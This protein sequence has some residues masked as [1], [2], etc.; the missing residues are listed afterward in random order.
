M[1]LFLLFSLICAFE[2]YLSS[3]VV[4]TA[5]KNLLAKSAV[6]RA[7]RIINELHLRTDIFKGSL[8]DFNRY[9]LFIL[10]NFMK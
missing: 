2:N 9:L 7:I 4:P 5:R 10:C 3:L 6:T 1:H 8:S